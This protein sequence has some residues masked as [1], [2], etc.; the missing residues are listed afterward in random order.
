M[1]RYF[2]VLRLGFRGLGFRVGGQLRGLGGWM[3]V[4]G[5]PDPLL[6]LS[7]QDHGDMIGFRV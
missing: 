7:S 5:N 2:R 3:Q 1:A 4:A 6:K